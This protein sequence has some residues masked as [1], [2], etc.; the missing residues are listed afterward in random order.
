MNLH[1]YEWYRRLR[2]GWYLV[3]T[4]SNTHSKLIEDNPVMNDV[5]LVNSEC[6]GIYAAFYNGD[7][8]KPRLRIRAK[9]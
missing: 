3:D 2:G 7:L 6:K 1:N 8:S 4:I 5:L 9:K